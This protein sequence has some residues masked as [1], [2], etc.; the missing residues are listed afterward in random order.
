MPPIVELPDDQWR[1]AAVAVMLVIGPFEASVGFITFGLSYTTIELG[2]ERSTVT[3][4]R[5]MIDD[6]IRQAFAPS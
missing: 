5:A 4:R 1:N 6:E 2:Y 3:K